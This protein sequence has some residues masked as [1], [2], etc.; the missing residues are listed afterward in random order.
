MP[1]R[2]SSAK[3]KATKYAG[4]L[5]SIQVTKMSRELMNVESGV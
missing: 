3:E 2:K 4:F 1:T 5:R